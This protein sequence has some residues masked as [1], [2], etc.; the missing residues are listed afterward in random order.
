MSDEPIYEAAPAPFALRR[1]GIIVNTPGQV[2]FYRHIYA[3]LVARGHHA[4]ILAR[5]ERETLAL[6]NEFGLPYDIFSRP[7][8]SKMSSI[9]SLPRNVI[10]ATNILKRHRVDIVTGFGVYDAYASALLGIPNLVFID[11]E[12]KIGKR[13]YEIQFRLF[14]PFVDH[15]ITPS[16]FKADLGRRHI[17]IDG[18]KE[19]AYLHPHNFQPDDSIL[20]DLS[21]GQGEKYTVL[22]FNGLSAFHDLG[23][24][25]FSDDDKERLVQKLEKDSIVLISSEKGVPPALED[26]VIQVPKK[27][28]HDVLYH[29]SL[30]VTDTQTMATEAAILGTPT[31]RCN[32]FVG[33]NDMGNFIQLEDRY[34]LLF[35]IKRPDEAIQKSIDLIKDNNAKEE[36][37]RKRDQLC[38]DNIDVSDLMTWCIEHFPKSVAELQADPNIQERFR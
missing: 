1:V 15:L 24:G 36:W 14:Y 13:S 11:N 7:P 12:P 26:R 34:H 19:F 35:N 9:F 29:A 23:V 28:I 8:T 6:L 25:G 16:Y 18:L 27:R 31:V 17:R 38:R 5:A 2:H 21:L 4:I 37:T 20:K 10:N 32:S 33:D 30:L 22:R 3:N